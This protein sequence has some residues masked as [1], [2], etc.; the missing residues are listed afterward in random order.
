MNQTKLFEKE[1]KLNITKQGS[2]ESLLKLA[3]KYINDSAKYK[4]VYNFLWLGRPII[5]FPQDMVAIQEIIWRVKP[6][7]I[8][9]TGIAHGGSIIFSASILEMI[10]SKGRIIGIDIDIRKHNRIAIVKHPLYKRITMLEGSSV[11][12][13]IVRKV[14]EMTKG[15]KT[16]VFLDSL[17]THS[18]VLKELNLYSKLVSKGSY[19][20]VFDTVVQFMNKKSFP[21]RPW[22]KNDNPYTAVQEFLIKNKH[23]IIDSEIDN[24]LLISSAPMGYLKRIK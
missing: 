1:K 15:K 11:E 10:G 8:I 21:N 2:D 5:Q 6:D 3:L 24:K 19:L 18:H 23:F 13:E 4:Y 20:V 17:H 22:D 16:M 7:F 14:T 9:E 12:L